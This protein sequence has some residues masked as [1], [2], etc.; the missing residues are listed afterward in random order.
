[1]HEKAHQELKERM[2]K[3]G[4]LVNMKAK[5]TKDNFLNRKEDEPTAIET[6]DCAA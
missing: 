6:F 5:I 4:L 1:M 2:K 3:R